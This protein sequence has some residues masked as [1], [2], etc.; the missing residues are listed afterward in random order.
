[1][2]IGNS[3]KNLR[4]NKN[5]TQEELAQHLSVSPQTVSKWEN[6]LSAPDISMLPVLAEFYNITIDELLQYD[7]VERRQKMTQLS[8]KIHELQSEGKLEEA[9]LLLKDQM[10]DW[11][12][13]VS[14]NHLYGSIAYQ[15]AKGKSGEE[16]KNL[17]YEAINQSDKVVNLDQNETGRTIQA[18]MLK[19][20]C[21]SMLERHKE[22]EKLASTL[23]SIFSSREIVLAK[24]GTGD[25]KNEYSRIAINY[26]NE[27]VETLN[28]TK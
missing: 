21:L 15:L 10:N 22:A 4:K 13:S 7:S 14:M 17:L 2:N 25:K 23:P 1:M 19:C 16:K 6:N 9:Y 27:L 20:Y 5:L 8:G 18:K 28:I 3:L 11:I 26:L 12:L 24:I